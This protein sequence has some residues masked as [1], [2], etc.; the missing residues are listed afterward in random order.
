MPSPPLWIFALCASLLVYQLGTGH[1]P[2]F[3]EYFYLQS[4]R[5]M[6]A[7]HDWITPI[8]NNH[9]RFDKPILL[10]WL[11]MLS[12]GLFGS[13]WFGARF[14]SAAMGLGVVFLTYQIG[15]I[16]F[17]RTTGLWAA[18]V[19]LTTPLFIIFAR[20]VI[21]DLTLTFFITLALFAF[22]R[23]IA[24][25]PARPSWLMLSYAA[26]ALAT[27]T[28]GPIGLLLPAMVIGGILTVRKN[29]PALRELCLIRGTV[30]FFAILLPWFILI[31]LKHGQDYVDY[32]SGVLVKAAV[33]RQRYH[34]YF[35]LQ[36]FF[37]DYLP[38]TL[39]LLSGIP[40]FRRSDPAV[41]S[42]VKV[43]LVWI[44]IVVVFFS[45]I[46]LKAPRYLLPMTPAL[47]LATA[48]VL[49][50]A[51]TSP[52]SLPGRML[53]GLSFTAA[54]VGLIAS[55]LLLAL[56][57]FV[58]N[59]PAPARFSVYAWPVLFAIASIGLLIA[60]IRGRGRSQAVGLAAVMAVGF[61]T[62]FTLTPRW[63]G[64]SPVTLLAE[65]AKADHLEGSRFAV[66]HL[67]VNEL[68]F[69]LGPPVTRLNSPEAFQLFLDSSEPGYIVMDEK[70]FKKFGDQLRVVFVASGWKGAR[71]ND[72]IEIMED[73]YYLTTKKS[74]S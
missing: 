26:M 41:R 64:P 17:S 45:F 31:L 63:E 22:L 20:N 33:G 62:Y 59:H 4:V 5:E 68:L 30:L 9:T 32:V 55:L 38:W 21:P 7:H 3:M 11:V 49:E 60:G 2:M 66:Y 69:T 67:H 23:G 10:Y 34:W 40:L 14:V 61:F 28:K 53:R 12:T 8:F 39:M 25:S 18:M 54:A 56:P 36:R 27:L 6:T 1:S 51:M 46:S 29:R 19:L 52:K 43:P 58:V 47:S 16:L 48:W 35:Y 24:S 37:Q 42:A 70:H 71:W 50:H 72:G 57:R 13:N 74:P 15:K 65:K 73:R 44:G